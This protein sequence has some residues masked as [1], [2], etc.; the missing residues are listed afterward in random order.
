[1]NKVILFFLFLS[2]IFTVSCNKS[3]KQQ[4]MV[5]N[6]ETQGNN[7]TIKIVDLTGIFNSRYTL[8]ISEK[9]VLLSQRKPIVMMTFFSPFSP[10]S[11]AQMHH[12]NR[13][14]KTYHK[15][16]FTVAFSNKIED[17]K[18]LD[19]VTNNNFNY[20]FVKSTKET[21]TLSTQLMQNINKKDTNIR[22]LTIIYL[23]GVYFSHYQ[24]IIP[25]EMIEFDINEAL[26]ILKS[27]KKE[28]QGFHV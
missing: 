23:K 27:Q 22:P 17:K 6:Q 25:P 11:L 28:S 24:G 5:L 20:F 9:K 8:K 1:M 3:E 14:Q 15:N 12:L 18:L 21:L 4:D 2:L 7:A 13:L 16:M 10:S 19:L 26:K